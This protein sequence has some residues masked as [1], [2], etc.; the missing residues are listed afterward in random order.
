MAGRADPETRTLLLLVIT[1]SSR[2]S[3]LNWLATGAP[4]LVCNVLMG[5]AGRSG[6][7]RATPATE[8]VA[9]RLREDQARV[10]ISAVPG[11]P[12]RT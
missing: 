12:V 9:T 1:A 11:R 8:P 3:G 2:P 5:E 10:P 6:S 7:H 4:S